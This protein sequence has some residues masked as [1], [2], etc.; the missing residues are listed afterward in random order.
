MTH[1]GISRQRKVAEA[2]KLVGTSSVPWVTFRIIS[3]IKRLKVTIIRPLKA[4]I[5]NRPYLQNRKACNL[6]GV[7]EANY[8]REDGRERCSVLFVLCVV[9]VVVTSQSHWRHTSYQQTS[10]CDTAS[11]CDTV[12]DTCQHLSV[13][14]LSCTLHR[15][16]LVHGDYFSSQSSTIAC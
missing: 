4:V 15:C 1:L 3:K 9:D 5:E 8:C 14:E 11:D 13:T 2:P 7:N 12:S 16:Q 6:P 10:D